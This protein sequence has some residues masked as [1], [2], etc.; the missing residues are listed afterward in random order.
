MPTKLKVR[1]SEIAFFDPVHRVDIIPQRP[2]L[3]VLAHDRAFCV[4]CKESICTCVSSIGIDRGSLDELQKSGAGAPHMS[5]ERKMRMLMHGKKKGLL[6]VMYGTPIAKIPGLIVRQAYNSTCGNQEQIA[7]RI[8][9]HLTNFLAKLPRQEENANQLVSQAASSTADSALLAAPEESGL[10]FADS[11]SGLS[12]V[13][14]TP[15]PAMRTKISGKDNVWLSQT[16]NTNVGQNGSNAAREFAA[17]VTADG[18]GVCKDVKSGCCP[19]KPEAP[20]FDVKTTSSPIQAS[21]KAEQGSVN[22]SLV[23]SIPSLKSPTEGLA[24]SPAIASSVC[25]PE[26]AGKHCD[27]SAEDM[28]NASLKMLLNSKGDRPISVAE[29]GH[30]A[31]PLAERLVGPTPLNGSSLMLQSLR[32]S[33][34]PTGPQDVLKEEENVQFKLATGEKPHTGSLSPESGKEVVGRFL[35][36]PLP[37]PQPLLPHGEPV[38]KRPR[39]E[40]TP[41]LDT[42]NFS[43]EP[44]W[45]L[46]RDERDKSIQLPLWCFPNLPE[47]PSSALSRALTIG[48]SPSPLVLNSNMQHANNMPNVT[49]S[50]AV[51]HSGSTGSGSRLMGLG[52]TLHASDFQNPFESSMPMLDSDLH[53][54]D[55]RISGL[56]SLA[57]VENKGLR[58]GMGRNAMSGFGRGER[59][60]TDRSVSGSGSGVRCEQ[61]DLVFAKRS[62]MLRHVQTVHKRVKEFEC[63][64]CGAK[65]GL[66]ADLRRHRYRL[67]ESRAFSCDKCGRSFAEQDQLQL[68]IRKVH[69]ED[70]RPWECKQCGLRF[71]RKS[72]M[73]RHEQTVHQQTRFPCRFCKKSYSQ[74]FDAT[75]HERKVHRFYE[76]HNG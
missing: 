5:W 38:L 75:R 8:D 39:V 40:N 27:C 25:A 16:R 19:T 26:K 42:L 36:S 21:P 53:S 55:Q 68:H 49:N 18:F 31:D 13:S 23:S 73:T 3:V 67:H 2:V 69:E 60:Q 33:V 64:I 56:T 63:N 4:E 44:G 24:Q 52:R 71:G 57:P 62:N 58:G 47:R 7:I 14:Y 15:S 51:N 17:A 41:K 72:S 46:G 48:R 59:R 66:K 37:P 45:H 74:K 12:P 70:S 30:F 32:A 29:V 35:Q 65:F 20:V 54:Q 9:Q 43:I 50:A 1:I 34:G 28:P 76:N 6:T 11:L 10:S 22:L 61:C